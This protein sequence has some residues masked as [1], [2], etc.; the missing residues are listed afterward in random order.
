ML[1][2]LPILLYGAL[3]RPFIAVSLWLWVSM[4]NPSGWVYGAAASNI[5]FNLIFAFITIVSILL[6]R[7]KIKTKN[8]INLLTFFVTVFLLWTV[9]T[10]LNTIGDPEIAWEY[11]ERFFKVTMLYYCA[12]FL[13]SKKLH[14]DFFIWMLIASVGF[15][16]FEESL[17]FVVSFGKHHIRGMNDHVLGDN[18]SLALAIDMCIP[19]VI[20]IIGQTKSKIFRWIL[21]GLVFSMILCVIGTYSRGG[22]LGLIV[23]A[24]IY[25][26]QS[27]RK[28]ITLFTI[29]AVA[30]LILSNFTTEQWSTRMDTI[31]K[32][33]KDSSFMGRVAAWKVSTLIA[34][35]NPITG[36]GIKS[37][38][39]F[40]IWLKYV[41][42]IDRINFIETPAPDYDRAHAAHSIYFQALGDQGFIGLFLV[43]S[44]LLSAYLKTSKLERQ[45]I[46]LNQ[47]WRIS[48]SKMLKISITVYA[49]VGGALS[50]VYFDLIFAIYAMVRVL[51]LIRE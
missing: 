35:D 25:F 29:S 15:Y 32:A 8:E 4:F 12:I 18:N 16:A 45:A 42:Q 43:V 6:N 11:W 10:T 46:E 33:S 30:L 22:M 49:I 40:P 48:L 34:I 1:A 19:L 23:I 38:E 24:F 50:M 44:L 31:S 47:D 51:E 3:K 39:N 20:Y 9:I 37:L 17:K 14:V 5:R 28:I 7:G 13:L 36:G 27:E 21:A 2:V 26:K 41:D